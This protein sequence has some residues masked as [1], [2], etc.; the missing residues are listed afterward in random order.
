MDRTATLAA[1]TPNRHLRWYI[2][3]LL[4]LPIIR[5][6]PWVELST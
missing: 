6:S 3:G 1:V 4:F 5:A 2:G